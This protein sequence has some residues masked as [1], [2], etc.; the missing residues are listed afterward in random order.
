MQAGGQEG[1]SA[2]SGQGPQGECSFLT[3]HMQRTSSG[4]GGVSTG[5]D[6]LCCLRKKVK[7]QAAVLLASTFKY[8]KRLSYVRGVSE[9]FLIYYFACAMK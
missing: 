7:C 2:G 4:N 5:S 8:P 9:V 6:S 1:C 3:Q